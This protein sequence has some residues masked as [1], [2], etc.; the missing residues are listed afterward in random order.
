MI[1]VGD[2]HLRRRLALVLAADR[3]LGRQSAARRG[4]PRARRARGEAR[5]RTR[6]R[7][8]A[9]ARRTRCAAPA[10]AA[11]AAPCAAGV[12]AARRTSSAARRAS[13]A[14]QHLLGEP[15]QVLD[16]RE[17]QHARPGPQLAD[18]QRRDAS[19]SCSRKR[20][21]LVAVEAAVAVADQL[22]RQGVDARVAGVLA[23]RELRQLAVVAARQ[24]LADVADLRRDQV[25]VVEQPLRRRRDE[26]APVHVVGQRAVGVA[27][28]AGVV[29]KRGKTL[30]ARRR[31]RRVDA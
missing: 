11:A 27:Q 14:S 8:A 4:G 31:G 9:A 5:G 18:R 7:A 29:A 6:A 28:D 23:R 1:D 16:E 13:R 17:L 15:P 25:E 12:D 2:R 3:V 19:G 10:A 22:D 24:V 26:L 20:T 30:R 21:Q